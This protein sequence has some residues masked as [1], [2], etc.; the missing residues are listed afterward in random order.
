MSIPKEESAKPAP[1]TP[2]I[3]KKSLRDTVMLRSPFYYF[4]K[5]KERRKK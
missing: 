2:E 5:T 4:L 1:T 3:L